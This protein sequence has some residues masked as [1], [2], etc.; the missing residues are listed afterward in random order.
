MIAEYLELYGQMV[1]YNGHEIEFRGIQY[2]LNN[3]AQMIRA[4]DVVGL[5]LELEDLKS[6]LSEFV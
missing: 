4:E 3:I 6:W 1:R 5:S 2:T